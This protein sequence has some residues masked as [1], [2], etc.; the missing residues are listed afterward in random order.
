VTIENRVSG[1]NIPS[2]FHAAVRKGILDAAKDGVLGFAVVDTHVSV[3]DG[4]AHVKDSNEM[5]FRLA[6]A[7]ALRMAL[8]N[9]GPVLLEPVMHVELAMPVEHQGDL[10]ADLNRRR[11]HILGIEN[12]TNGAVLNAEVPLAEL[13]GYA[14]AIR[15]LSRGRAAY[16]MTPSHFD[17]VPKAVADALLKEAA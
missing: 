14:D 13:W 3:L 6:A 12:R 15:S 11:S 16:S 5:A 1:G 8:R 10:V 9:A 4:A 17:Q 2:Q 7:E